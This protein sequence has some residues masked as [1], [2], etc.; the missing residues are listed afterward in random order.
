[1][2]ADSELWAQWVAFHLQKARYALTLA[3]ANRSK[4]ADGYKTSPDLIGS[5]K[6]D[7]PDC[8]SLDF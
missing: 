2:F 8:L 6:S 7:D 3:S 4:G 5:F 1:V